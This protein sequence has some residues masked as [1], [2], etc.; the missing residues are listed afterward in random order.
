MGWATLDETIR[1][2]SML[3]EHKPKAA[4]VDKG[5]QGVEVG[6]VQILRSGQRRGATRTVKAKIKRRSAIEPTCGERN[7]VRLLLKKLKL[8]CTQI[9]MDFRAR[10]DAMLI[11]KSGSPFCDGLEN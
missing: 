5:F 8:L 9:Q 2:V 4:I 1:Q 11:G 7:N 10:M 3:A 6:V